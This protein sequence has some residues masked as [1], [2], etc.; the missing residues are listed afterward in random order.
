[1]KYNLYNGLSITLDIPYPQINNLTQDI[2]LA[3][4]LKKVYS[5]ETSE[6]TAIHNYVYQHIIF[7]NKEL[8]E[9]LRKISVV[10]MHHLDLLGEMIKKL[11]LYPTYTY[12]NKKN[13][14]TYWISDVVSYEDDLIKLMKNNIKNEEKAIKNYQKIINC[15]NNEIVNNVLERIIL[16][17][18]Q[19]IEIFTAIMDNLI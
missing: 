5:G 17:E 1:M 11:G 15:S 10:E 18:R 6:L 9:V 3:Y 14:E 19:H 16:D 8:K 12:I 7:T 13:N 2:N 4:H